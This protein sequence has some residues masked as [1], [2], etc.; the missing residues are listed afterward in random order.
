MTCFCRR[1]NTIINDRKCHERSSILSRNETHETTSKGWSPGKGNK[2][3]MKTS[4]HQTS[5][6]S[7]QVKVSNRE[8]SSEKENMKK[9][10]YQVNYKNVNAKVL[11]QL[12][13]VYDLLDTFGINM[14]FQDSTT[15]F[16][17][18]RNAAK[19]NNHTF[20]GLAFVPLCLCYNLCN[21][22]VGVGMDGFHLNRF[23]SMSHHA[24]LL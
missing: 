13:K 6:A 18:R 1:I 11:K 21:K 3:H 24:G 23:D 9:A 7:G 8:K 20:S 19:E 12:H 17:D 15:V 2:T 16:I 5:S 10:D 4:Q 14:A 22:I